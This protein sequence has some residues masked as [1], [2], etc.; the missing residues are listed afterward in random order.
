[1]LPKKSPRLPDIAGQS[2]RRIIEALDDR[3]RNKIMRLT[4]TKF[5]PLNAMLRRT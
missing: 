2:T 5:H 1:M 3:Q 4:T